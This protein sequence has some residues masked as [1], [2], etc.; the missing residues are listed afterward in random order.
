MKR[1]VIISLTLILLSVPSMSLGLKGEKEVIYNL[2]SDHYKGINEG[3]SEDIMEL[4]TEDII[5]MPPYSP[6][7]IGK[8][9]VK[10]FSKNTHNNVAFDFNY[11]VEE[12]IITGDWAFARSTV[13]GFLISKN[14][15]AAIL[16]QMKAIHIL[17]K[18]KNGSW[19]IARFIFNPSTPPNK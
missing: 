11:K 3:R 14:K 5:L 13:R 18:Q 19:K 6:E 16:D 7:M 12:I 1:F 17:Q 2:V 10:P 9:N 4:Y 15:K 8:E